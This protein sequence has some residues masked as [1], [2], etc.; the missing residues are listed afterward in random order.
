MPNQEWAVDQEIPAAADFEDFYRASRTA[1]VRAV[2]LVVGNADLGREAADETFTR[3]LDKWG[4][5]STYA[6]P[7]GWVYRIALNWVRSRIRTRRREERRSFVEPWY[8]DRVPEPELLAAVE[9]LPFKFRS[10]VVARFFLD[11]SIEQ[12]AEALALPEGTVKTLQHRALSRL[13]TSL[14]REA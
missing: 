12:T 5:V 1:I 7:A 8:E 2:V 11:W 3:A 4:Q 14:G 9:E 6:N 13:R 10:V